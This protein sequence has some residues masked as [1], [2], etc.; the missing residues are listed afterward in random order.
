MIP[1]SESAIFHEKL[2][3]GY[4]YNSEVNIFIGLDIKEIFAKLNRLKLYVKDIHKHCKDQC[5]FRDEVEALSE[6]IVKL[7]NLAL[8]LKLITHSRSKRGLIDAVGSISK[9][10]FGTL[11]NNDLNLINANIDK[12]FEGENELKTIIG[13]QTALI[14]K[15]INPDGLKQVEN[16][17]NELRTT[18]QITKREEL[19]TSLI[20][21]AESAIHDLHFQLDEILNVILLGKQGIISPQIINH[22]IFIKTYG[23]AL[24]YKV[25]NNAIEP[26]EE[27]F[28]FIL[29]IAELKV[30]TVNNKDF[31]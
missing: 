20:I 23:K 3:K 29:N 2:N 11:D 27:N 22:E 30:F 1:L 24:G 13:K 26:H 31:L 5:R 21:K 7:D 12:L 25:Y 9:S 16:L 17:A 28:Q 10:L 4:L 6:R 18:E 8:H 19:M 14:K 15:I